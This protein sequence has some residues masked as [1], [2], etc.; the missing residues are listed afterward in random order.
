VEKN[1]C[2]LSAKHVVMNGDDVQ[3]MST[4]RLQHRS[5]FRFAHGDVTSNLCVGV[6]SG[7]SCPGVQAHAGVDG[8]T[9]LLE[10]EVVAAQG[11]FVDGTE[12]FALAPHDGVEGRE[13]K[14]RPGGGV[15]DGAAAGG[16]GMRSSAGL[17][18]L[19]RSSALP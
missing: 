15:V 2:G 19:A 12:S 4:K 11:E 1:D 6:A 10:N 13:I 3:L 16:R 14:C 18:R 7:K 5:N 8:C 17:R 9:V